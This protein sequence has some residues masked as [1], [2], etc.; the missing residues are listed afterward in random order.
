M[1]RSIM[2]WKGEQ[3]RIVCL[4]PVFIKGQSMLFYL[5]RFIAPTLGDLNSF[6]HSGTI[7]FELFFGFMQVISP[8]YLLKE[9]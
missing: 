4:R 1:Y 2:I 6:I 8:Y 3:R 5:S 7:M 9:P